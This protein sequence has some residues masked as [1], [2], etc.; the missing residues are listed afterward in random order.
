[1]HKVIIPRI[2]DLSIT[3][4][5]NSLK[6][7]FQKEILGLRAKGSG[8]FEG[9]ARIGFKGD[10]EEDLHYLRPRGKKEYQ[11]NRNRPCGR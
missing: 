1:L 8:I 5:F 7:T 6:E 2:L 11:L 4:Y 3:K 10:R 9:T